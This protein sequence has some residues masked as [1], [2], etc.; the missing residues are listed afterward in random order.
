MTDLRHQIVLGAKR[1][2]YRKHGDPYVIAGHSLRYLPGTRPVRLGYAM[3]SNDNN[4]NDA[5][6]IQLLTQQLVSEPIVA[7]TAF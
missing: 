3:S 1:L 6:Q 4:R 5:L 2:I 7:S